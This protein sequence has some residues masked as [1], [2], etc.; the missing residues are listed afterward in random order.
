MQIQ[1]R[2]AQSTDAPLLAQIFIYAIGE[3]A[4]RGYCGEDYRS[5]L[6][7]LC[8]SKGCQYYYGN[9]LVAE[10]DGQPVGGIIGYDGAQL[11]PLRKVTL[12]IISRYNPLEVVPQDETEA[13]EFYIDSLGILPQFRGRGI[14]RELLKAMCHRATQ[15]GHQ[16]IGLLVDKENPN[17]ERL[18]R[19]I[20]FCEVGHKTFFGHH[21]KHLVLHADF[22]KN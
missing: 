21:M 9:A 16:R 14:G 17:A 22:K 8:Q 1:I 6:I 5:V 12:D 18:Y 2:P 13:G 10:C 19:S 7:T 11:V 15:M 4:A 3:E 20:G